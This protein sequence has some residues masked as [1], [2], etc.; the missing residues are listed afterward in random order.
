MFFFYHTP[1]PLLFYFMI[2]MMIL[3]SPKYC[4]VHFISYLHQLKTFSIVLNLCS[5]IPKKGYNL[6]TI[7]FCGGGDVK[8]FF[9][10]FEWIYFPEKID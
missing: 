2:I 7:Y 9:L 5:R 10:K 6:L 3:H 8:H 4:L 1:R